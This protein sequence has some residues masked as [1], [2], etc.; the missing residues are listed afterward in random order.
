MAYLA[1]SYTVSILNVYVCM[2]VCMCTHIH[3]HIQ[4]YI[5]YLEEQKSRIGKYPKSYPGI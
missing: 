4:T 2:C 1:G 3:T 5:H